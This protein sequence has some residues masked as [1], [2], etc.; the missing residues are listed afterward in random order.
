[1]VSIR[2]IFKSGAELAA[3]NAGGPALASA[4]ESRNGRKALRFIGYP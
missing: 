4:G 3:A 1:V 2:V